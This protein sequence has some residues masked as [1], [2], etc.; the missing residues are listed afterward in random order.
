MVFRTFDF[1][2]FNIMTYN[3]RTLDTTPH[4]CDVYLSIQ[5]DM[6]VYENDMI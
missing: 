3:L 4:R 5:D 6:N 2:G 1:I